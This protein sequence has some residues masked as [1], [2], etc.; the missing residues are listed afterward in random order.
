MA[1]EIDPPASEVALGLALAVISSS[2]APLLLLNERLEIVVASRSFCRAFALKPTTVVGQTMAE[3]GAGEWDVPQLDSLLKATASGF[4]EVE[5]YEMN[6]QRVDRNPRRLVVNAHKLDYQERGEVRI[7]L[8]VLDVT[9]ARRSEKQKDEL[10]REKAILLQE[11]QHRVAN[12][13]QII[14]SVLMQSARKVQSDESRGHLRDAHH[15]VMSVAALQQQLATSQVGDVPLKPYLTSLCRS[16]G[17]SMIHDHE[18]LALEVEVDDS[19]VG[20]DRSISIG[21]VVTELVINALKHAYPGQRGGRILVS[22]AAS[23]ANWTLTVA[24][25]GVGMPKEAEDAK[26]GLGTSIVKALAA[27]LGAEITVI[28]GKPGT[29]VT[30]ASLA[31]DDASGPSTPEP[32]GA[33]V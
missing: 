10:L 11:L 31:A 29:I 1:G 28:E 33:A 4:A 5:A 2:D 18:A 17:A 16:I 32:V 19:V 26:A 22:Y 27:Q 14:A 3:L 7:L 13:L 25:D 15:R 12:S 21:L 9:D 8:S 30:L 20:A 6:L 24:D 23:G